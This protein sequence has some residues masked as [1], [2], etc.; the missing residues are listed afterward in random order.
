MAKK[1]RK[2]FSKLEKAAFYTGFGVGL[3]GE[4]STNSGLTSKAYGM[5][6]DKEKRSYINGYAKGIGNSSISSGFRFKNRWF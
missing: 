6:S 4:G 5:M 3:T 2:S 1:R